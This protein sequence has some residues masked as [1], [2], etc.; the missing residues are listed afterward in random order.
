MKKSV[1][2]VL[3]SL[4]IATM[5]ANISNAGEFKLVAAEDGT[6]NSHMT[7][8]IIG[9]TLIVGVHE[10]FGLA[11]IYVGGGKKWKVQAE[12][13]ALEGGREGG[14]DENRGVPGFGWSVALTAPHEFASADYAVIGA[15]RDHAAGELSG[16]AYIF[17][18]NRMTWKEQAKL[19]AG[20]TAKGDN[21]GWAV[22]IDRNTA[23][24]GAPG[25]DDAGSSSGA[26]FVFEFERIKWK[27][28]AKLIPK[29]LDRS[30]AL[31]TSVLVQKDT[32][33]VGAPNHTHSGVRF[34]GAAFVFRRDGDKWVEH[35]MLTA[36][37]AAKSDSFGTSIAI[38]GDTVVVGAPLADTDRGKDAGAVYAFIRDGDGWKQQAKLGSSDAKKAD[39]F[40]FS[41]AI[42]GNNVIVGAKTRDEGEPGSGAAYSF[43]RSNGV[44]EQKQKVAP[45]DPGQKINYGTWVAVSG[46]TVIV[47]AHN[48]PNDGPEWGKGATVHIYNGIEDFDAVPYS[49]ESFGLAVTTFGKIRRT[50][51]LQNFPNPFNPETWLPY[52]LAADAPV[53]IHIYNVQGHLIRELNLGVQEAGGYLSR[54]AA[55]YWDGRDQLGQTVSSGIYFYALQAGTF[56]ATRRMFILK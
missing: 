6:R 20:D 56:R 8:D 40:G 51:L 25:D 22:A 50:S 26:A 54:E 31:G 55:A 27:E 4:V 9:D 18:R 44:W 17:A 19:I 41:V 32:I 11:K 1:R 35:T 43:V 42:E 53:A 16:S 5:L 7:A 39:Q 49:V 2:F 37:D 12:L 10:G 34:T 47:S 48:G 46:N 29:D 13:S 33:I 38:S 24:I 45:D 23:V 30:A 21:F 52:Q 36:D 28:K 15:A 14:A 3:I